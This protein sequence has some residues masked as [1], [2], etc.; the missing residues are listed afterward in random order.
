MCRVPCS[1]IRP[2]PNSLATAANALVASFGSSG[3]LRQTL[4]TAQAEQTRRHERIAALERDVQ[5]VLIQLARLT[6][7]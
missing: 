2:T 3:P 5:D 6:E 7:L 1:V 4:A